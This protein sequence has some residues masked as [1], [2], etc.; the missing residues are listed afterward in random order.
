MIDS[1]VESEF[2]CALEDLALFVFKGKQFDCKLVSSWYSYRQVIAMRTDIKSQKQ[3]GA[4]KSI[5]L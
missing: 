5:L 3:E 1:R 2:R 4:K